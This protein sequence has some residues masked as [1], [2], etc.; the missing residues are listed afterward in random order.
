MSYAPCKNPSCKSFGTPHP[1]CHCYVE[2]AEGGHPE[3]YCSSDKPHLAGC[4]Y[5]KDGGEVIDPSE[6][7]IDQPAPEQEINPDEV[8]IEG[9]LPKTEINPDEVVVEGEEPKFE[10]PMDRIKAIAEGVGRGFLSGPV[11]NLAEE[12]LLGVKSEDI[13]A[14]EKRY[15][16]EAGLSELGGLAA[17]SM[18]GVGALGLTTKLL[19]MA[20][21]ARL[22]Q[23]GATIAR[24]ALTGGIIQGLDEGSKMMLGLTDPQ[25]GAGAAL[26]HV[27]GAMLLGGAIPGAL[28]QVA[29]SKAGA[30][31]SAAAA[32]MASA[33]ENASGAR[34]KVDSAVLDA[35]AKDF[36][37]GETGLVDAYQKGQEFF[38]KNIGKVLENLPAAAGY[39][40]AGP[41]GAAIGTVI[42]KA[43]GLDKILSNVTTPIVRKILTPLSLKIISANNSSGLI[44]AL[45]HAENVG[46]GFGVLVDGVDA[47]FK[48]APFMPGKAY[49]TMKDAGKLDDYIKEGGINHQA[50]QEMHDQPAFGE[51]PRFAHGGEVERPHQKP[52]PDAL[53]KENDGLAIHYPEQNII[54]NQAKGRISNYLSSLRPQENL[55]GLAFDAK[56]NQKEQKRSYD[57]A[58]NIALKPLSVLDKVQD[59]TLE[60][61]HMKHF[62]SMFPEVNSLLMKKLT[63][64]IVKAQMGGEKPTYK[65]RQGLSMLMGAALSSEFQPQNIMA[66]QQVFQKQQ[67]AASPQQGQETAGPKK[68]KQSLS[69]SS[70]AFLTGSQALV[71]RQQRT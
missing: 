51:P 32:G 17:G 13:A 50:I 54:M 37:E 7:V 19:G 28:K 6:V 66:A 33:A 34:E 45:G 43:T 21:F 57:R 3:R 69:K 4:Q 52:N 39:Y 65:V 68:N 23:V 30:K 58:L 31:L 40:K 12:H 26:A 56:P 70:Q 29:I 64:R 36:G 18:T 62:T 14:R 60:P 20:K 8:Q 61:E 67:Q 1:N 24:G 48:T 49:D 10:D 5:F 42:G 22:G 2:M 25:D 27:G 38:D 53:L 59:G 41:A 47:L 71:S 63:E 35:L 11:A 44:D 15:P 16:V 9:E 46:K 55:P